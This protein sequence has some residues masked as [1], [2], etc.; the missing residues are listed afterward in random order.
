MATTWRH[1]LDQQ[2]LAVDSGHW[3]LFRFDPR[4]LAEGQK[5]TAARQ[6]AAQDS[7]QRLYPQRDPVPEWS[8]GRTRPV[9]SSCSPRRRR[10]C[11][12]AGTIYAWM[13]GFAEEG[14]LAS[15]RVVEAASAGEATARPDG[16]TGEGEMTATTARRPVDPLLRPRTCRTRSSL[17]A[18]GAV[19]QLGRHPPAGGC[20]RCGDRAAV[21]VRGATAP[22]EQ[23]ATVHEMEVH[24]EGFAEALS[25]F[26]DPP[27]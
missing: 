20:G 11:A 9:G 23:L 7:A 24:D 12:C 21:A 14:G 2:K 25:F 26:P 27:T 1:G 6:R 15:R 3:P 17:A 5:A 8:S 22:R 4:R 18:S 19:R 16:R 10:T 13:A